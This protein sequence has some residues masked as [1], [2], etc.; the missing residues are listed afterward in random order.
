[1]AG[2][3]A[4]PGAILRLVALVFRP[5]RTVLRLTLRRVFGAIK[6]NQLLAAVKARLAV[7]GQIIPGEFDDDDQVVTHWYTYESFDPSLN[8]RELNKLLRTGS[9]PN[10]AHLWILAAYL[11]EALAKLPPRKGISFRVIEDYPGFVTM[12][13]ENSIVTEQSFISSSRNPKK[14]LPGIIYFTLVGKSGRNIGGMSRFLIEDEVL[15]PPQT[16]FMVNVV[17]YLT[18]KT[19]HVVLEEQ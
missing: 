7:S 11:N 9:H 13:V 2:N 12:Y 5:V 4:L 6:Y 14:R 18:D 10:E 8:Y 17:D 19:I 15:F 16:K 1:M 3:D